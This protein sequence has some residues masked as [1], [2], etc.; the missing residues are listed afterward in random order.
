MSAPTSFAHVYCLNTG[1]SF[2]L[3]GG[4]SYPPEYTITALLLHEW[5][6]VS[7]TTTLVPISN[8][9]PSQPPVNVSTTAPGKTEHF[10]V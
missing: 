9:I 7:L 10:Q 6:S 2:I 4:G 3:L 5:T 1:L 8:L